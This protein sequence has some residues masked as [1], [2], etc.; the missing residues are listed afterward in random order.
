MV[1]RQGNNNNSG[2]RVQAEVSSLCKPSISESKPRHNVSELKSVVLFGEGR[3]GIEHTL[4]HIHIQKRS[5]HRWCFNFGS[6]CIICE[7][8]QAPVSLVRVRTQRPWLH[9][10]LP[11]HG[12][13]GLRGGQS[14]CSV[15][16]QWTV[17][18]PANLTEHCFKLMLLL[19]PCLTCL[20]HEDASSK[21]PLCLSLTPPSRPRCFSRIFNSCQ[22]ASRFR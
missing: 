17:T 15:V 4:T 12:R 3:R 5:H 14:Q 7:C 2:Q 20:Y 21:G 19:T 18:Q 1:H 22:S 9:T 10:W 6:D 8:K 13:S 16:S 11:A